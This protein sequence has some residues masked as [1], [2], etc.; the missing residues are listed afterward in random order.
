MPTTNAPNAVSSLGA[1]PPPI[2]GR[3]AAS[4]LI[5]AG[6]QCAVPRPKLLGIIPGAHPAC[7]Y[8]CDNCR[9]QVWIDTRSGA[10]VTAPL[11]PVAALTRAPSTPLTYKSH[12]LVGRR[13]ETGEVKVVA[14]W[15][16]CPTQ[17]DIHA[18]QASAKYKYSEFALTEAVNVWKP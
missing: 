12:V 14:D 4:C 9:V 7:H 11:P 3:L 15:P 5:S 8:K 6:C 17:K 16:H 1:T 10:P 13:A 2:S 18:A